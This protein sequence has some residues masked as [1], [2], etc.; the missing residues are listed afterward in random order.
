MACWRSS[1]EGVVTVTVTYMYIYIY[2]V[3]NGV[4]IITASTYIN[5]YAHFAS[6][7]NRPQYQNSHTI[8]ATYLNV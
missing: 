2:I 5:V 8:T 3:Q 7:T 1:L 6:I 4:A